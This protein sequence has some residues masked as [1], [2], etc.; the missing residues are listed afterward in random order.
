MC[1][2]VHDDVTSPNLYW[3]RFSFFRFFIFNCAFMEIDSDIKEA[4]NLFEVLDE[5][6]DGSIDEGEF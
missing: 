6:N 3:G 4:I 5:N 1:V 2:R